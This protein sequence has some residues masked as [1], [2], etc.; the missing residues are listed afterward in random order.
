M[1]GLASILV[2]AERDPRNVFF[3]FFSLDKYDLIPLSKSPSPSPASSRPSVT[4]EKKLRGVFGS[5]ALEAK[6]Q[7]NS[8]MRF[9][10]RR[11]LL[12]LVYITVFLLVKND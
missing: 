7:E 5:F 2:L 3:D 10:H 8:F 6:A 1:I 9:N 11:V 4:A 12:Q